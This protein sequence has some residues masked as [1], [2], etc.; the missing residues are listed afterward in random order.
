V[1]GV[2]ASLTWLSESEDGAAWLA[3][4]PSLIL[5]CTE[6][7]RLRLGEPYSGSHVSFVVPAVRVDGTAVV[8]KVQWPHRESEHEAAALRVWDGAGAVRLIGYDGDLHALL[9]ERC[10][11]GDYLSTMDGV[12][13]LD[14]LV[15]LLPRLWRPAGA[16]FTALADE[17]VRWADNLAAQVPRMAE[18]RTIDAAVGILRELAADQGGQEQ[19]LLHQDL[20]GDNVLRAGREPWLV[21]DPKPL[22]GE[23]AFGL[24]PIVRSAELGDSRAAVR[25]RLDRLTAELGVDRV[26]ARG[27]AYGQTVA[28]GF[29][30]GVVSP[31]HLAV[32]DYLS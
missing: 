8:L 6:R 9:L 23:R 20:H 5:R 16:P 13:A 4:L 10:V 1:V 27:W 26:R 3:S 12:L 24:A 22:A 17:A 29:D 2:P 31:W 18:R 7:W 15:E 25:Y 32:A 11:P 19:V 28:W 14:V 21:I 30:D